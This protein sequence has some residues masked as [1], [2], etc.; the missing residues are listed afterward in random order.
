MSQY[1]GVSVIDAINPAAAGNAVAGANAATDRA[2]R[3]QLADQEAVQRAAQSFADSMNQAFNRKHE[4]DLKEREL[5][6]T[7]QL[8]EKNQKHESDLQSQKIT[9]DQQMQQQA[10][11]QQQ[12]LAQYNSER[13]LI[14]AQATMGMESLGKSVSDFGEGGDPNLAGGGGSVLGGEGPRPKGSPLLQGGAPAE[15]EGDEA[16]EPHDDNESREY[17]KEA[18]QSAAS[19]Q[20]AHQLSKALEDKTAEVGGLLQAKTALLSTVAPMLGSLVDSAKATEVVQAEIAN[21]AATAA[22]MVARSATELDM[23]SQLGAALTMLKVGTGR[24]ATNPAAPVPFTPEITSWAE[25]AFR[26]ISGLPYQKNEV[27]S[28]KVADSFTDAYLSDFANQLVQQGNASAG[29]VD[30]VKLKISTVFKGLNSIANKGVDPEKKQKLSDTIKATMAVFF[31]NDTATTEIY[32]S[33]KVLGDS[34]RMKEL[35]STGSSK[36]ALNRPLEYIPTHLSKLPR[37]YRDVMGGEPKGEKYKPL[38]MAML[39]MLASVLGD[40]QDPEQLGAW[41][42]G[43]SLS[44]ESKKNLKDLTA[45]IAGAPVMTKAAKAQKELEGLRTKTREAEAAA[46]T[47]ENKAKSA[48][49]SKRARVRDA[50]KQ[51]YENGRKKILTD[52]QAQM[53]ALQQKYKMGASPSQGNANAPR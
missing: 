49:A 27:D 30:E 21:R 38:S 32:T 31:F 42:E 13:D 16:F 22:D 8:Q 9:A 44:P 43:L 18:T 37:A 52:L 39:P 28:K 7:Q 11:A 12:M 40:V 33:L 24:G 19:I 29:S 36:N 6:V 47:A 20:M 15:Y 1:P 53:Q 3:Q 46:E 23:T 2:A 34:E 41:V 45:Q 4:R 10:L 51:E 14:L 5:Q 48:L 26:D 50:R 35:A 25:R 17:I